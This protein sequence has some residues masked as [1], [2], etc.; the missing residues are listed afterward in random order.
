MRRFCGGFTTILVAGRCLCEPCLNSCEGGVG[1]AVLSWPGIKAGM[2][3]VSPTGV[4]PQL[5][6]N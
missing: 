2:R 1:A 3:S 6:S 5:N 4:M